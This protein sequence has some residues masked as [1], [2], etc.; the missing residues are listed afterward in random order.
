LF[1]LTI[2]MVN[3]SLAIFVREYSELLNLIPA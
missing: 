3:P 2:E 1:F